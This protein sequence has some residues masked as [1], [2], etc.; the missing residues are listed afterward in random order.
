MMPSPLRRRRRGVLAALAASLLAASALAAVPAAAEEAPPVI[1]TDFESGLDGWAPRDSG[2]GAPTVTVTDA[3]AHAGV[4][5]ALIADRTSQGSGIIRD[6]TGVLIPGETYDLTAWV[7]FAPGQPADA[8]WASMART[9]AGA[10][11]YD[12]I[13]QHA[14]ATDTGW[15]QLSARFTMGAA[16]SAQLYFETAYGG[17][18]T[19][20]L[21]VDDIVVTP[22]GDPQ[23]EDAVPLKDTV[24]FPVGVAIDSRETTGAAAELLTRHFDQITPENHMKPEAWYDADRVFTPHPEAIALMDFARDEGLRLYGHVLVWHGQTPAWFFEHDDGT[25]L[26]NSEADQAILAERMRTHI[27]AVAEYLS[28]GWGAFGAENP[29]VALDVVNEV[30]D[31]GAQYADG[32]RRSRWYDVLG[33]EFVDLAFQYADEAFNH[34]Y[35]ADGADRP[36]TL[37]INDYNTEQAGKQDRYAALVDR[38]LARGVPVDGVGHQFHVSLSTP[39]SALAGALDRFADVGVTQAVTELDVTTGTPVTDAL[40]VDQGYYYRAVFDAFRERA[41]EL[42]SVSVWGLTDGRSWRVDSGAPLLFD[43]ALQ[44]KPAFHGAAGG[45]LPPPARSASVFQG[46]VPLDADAASDVA[47]RQLPLHE[48]G[49]AAR[50]QLRWDADRLTVFVEVDD[51]TPGDDRVVLSWNDETADVPRGGGAEVEA[52]VSE[53]ATGYAVVAALPLAAAEGDSVL[54]DVRVVDDGSPRGGWSAEGTQGSL[55]LVGPL[56]YAEVPEA[57]S[58]PVIDGAPDDVWADAATVATDIQVDGEAGATAQA[59]LLWRD[60]VLYV[61]A[62]VA[63]P[64]VDVSGVDPWIQDSVEIYVDAGNAKNGAYRAQDMQLRVNADGVVSFGAGDEAAQDA[65]TDTAAARTETGYVVE[66]AIR[67]DGAGGPG[68]FQGLDVQVNDAAAGA[69]TG[70]RNWAD[71]TGLGYQST[72]RWGVVQLVTAP[73]EPSI[74]VPAGAQAGAETVVTVTGAA[75]GEMVEVSAARGEGRTGEVIGTAAADARGVAEVTVALPDRPG[76]W[77]LTASAD[78]DVLA[79]TR[80]KLSR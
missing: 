1:A 62:E 77:Q 44:A 74:T 10:T 59:R 78:G 45:E 16:E 46:A 14:A 18:N 67:L 9:T 20:D 48:A 66:A 57:A 58:A 70:I 42:F 30:I 17:T 71:P 29:L 12:T 52:V 31:D 15:T 21:L 40:L 73:Q 69:R 41:G 26:T 65:R 49:D 5:A 22:V 33:E 64:V 2:S 25:P 8:V 39:V 61:R 43:D 55:A 34:V 79:Q 6:V 56:A 28:S 36:V 72:A 38:L 75:P 32:M 80:V 51:T 50:F 76:V 13:A 3:D 47:W 24:D 54:F 68:T 27:F 53:T 11:S 23:V 4:G 37:F 19:S 7:R 63:D 60:D 35:A